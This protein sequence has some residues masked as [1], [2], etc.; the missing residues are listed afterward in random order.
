MRKDRL[1]RPISRIQTEAMNKWWL[2][3][4][5]SDGV[6]RQSTGPHDLFGGAGCR[7]EILREGAAG[8]VD[9]SSSEICLKVNFNVFTS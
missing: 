2:G 7:V 6:G 4:V 3:R 1:K 5:E 9:G 8:V